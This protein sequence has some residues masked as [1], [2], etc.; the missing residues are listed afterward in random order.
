MPTTS[1][2]PS[3]TARHRSVGLARVDRRRLAG[4]QIRH[5]RTGRT[6][7]CRSST[8]RSRVFARHRAAGPKCAAATTCTSCTP[9][10]PVFQINWNAGRTPPQHQTQ[11]RSAGVFTRNRSPAPLRRTR[12]APFTKCGLG[13]PALESK[14]L[15]TSV[16]ACTRRWL[17]VSGLALSMPRTQHIRRVSSRSRSLLVKRPFTK[18]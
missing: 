18:R 6:S 7:S 2:A 12:C 16:K 9:G 15:I 1:G 4:R 3:A 5:D 13:V 17:I 14:P 11:P 8:S 10:V